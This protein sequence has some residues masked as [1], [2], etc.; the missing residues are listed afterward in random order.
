M[1]SSCLVSGTS[2]GSLPFSDV[3]IG[4]QHDRGHVLEGDTRGLESGLEAVRWSRR[5]EHRHGRFAIATVHHL[6]E[7]GLLG[8]G[9]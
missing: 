4:E 8:L 2:Q 5:G 7:I 9:R 1:A 6:K 3:T